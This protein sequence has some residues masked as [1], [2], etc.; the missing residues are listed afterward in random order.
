MSVGLAVA[1]LGLTALAMALL[2]VPLL[3]HQRPAESSE[4]YNLAVYRD[5]L[6][7]ID[8][9]VGRGLL[10]PEQA[11]AARAEIGRRA[12]SLGTGAAPPPPSR[13]LLAFATSAVLMVPLVAWILYWQLGS[14][15]LPDAPF[16]ARQAAAAAVAGA[17][18]P[19]DMAQ[20]VARLAA[21]MQK[22]PNDL[23]GWVLLGRSYVDLGRYQDAVDAYR[24][25]VQL[26]GRRADLVGDWG[27]AQVLAAGGTVTPDAR[28]A[29]EAA[30]SSPETAPRSRYYL[31]LY[32]YQQGNPKAALQSWVDLEA[33]SPADA[34]WMKLL[35]QRIADTAKALGIDPATLKPSSAK[36]LPVAPRATAAQPASR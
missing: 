36:A 12:L 2:L 5:Q 14:P 34:A 24:H 18:A 27:E 11:D 13:R 31:A 7:E 22:Q 20:A 25:A 1:L 17:G 3:W 30:L 35:R 21:H 32:Q 26:S 19:L 10:G 29:F 16:A 33:D 15:A 8:R 28:Q 9:D 4:P 6:A 23:R